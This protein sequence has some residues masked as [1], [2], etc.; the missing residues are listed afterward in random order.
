[1]FVEDLKF[2]PVKGHLSNDSAHCL[3]PGLRAEMIVELCVASCVI[4]FDR[5]ISFLGRQCLP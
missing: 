3:T 1:M 4:L 2:N 5:P